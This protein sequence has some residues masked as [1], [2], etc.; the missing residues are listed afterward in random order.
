LLETIGLPELV[1]HSLEDYE[2]LALSLARDPA[3]LQGLRARLQANRLTSPLYDTD[4]F[5][6]DLETA[7]LRTME[8]ARAGQAAESFAVPG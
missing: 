1:T 2:K 8:I 5:R 6:R 7:Y 4:R 3:R